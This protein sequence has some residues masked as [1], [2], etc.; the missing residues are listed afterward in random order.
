MRTR[1]RIAWR[2][3]GWRTGSSWIVVPDLL[4]AVADVLGG[5][6]RVVVGVRRALHRRQV[7]QPEGDVLD[8]DLEVVRPLAVRQRRED[9]ARLGV[10][11][12]GLDPV[13]VPPEQGVRERAVAP[14][15][16]APVE[17]DE[18]EGHR[19]EEPPAVRAGP[20]RQAHHQPPVLERV[21]QELRHEDRAVAGR[22]LG[23][24]GRLDRRQAEALEVEQD[25]VLL[26]GD[27]RAA[28][29]SGRRG[30][31][32][33]RGTGR[34][35]ATGRPGR[36]GTRGGQPDHSASGSSHGRSTRSIAGSRRRRRGKT[37]HRRRSG[38]GARRPGRGQSRLRR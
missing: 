21:R 32:S 9:L 34:G 10:D 5:V 17:V 4:V 24:A 36:S 35:G 19:V 26:A 2:S 1:F 33:R 12:V 23:D 27:R 6:D 28:A 3:S 31:R 25:V 13:A 38:V 8:E 16:A 29:P 15:H 22:R 20:G 18:Q 37:G 30:C 11:E 14:E 7:G